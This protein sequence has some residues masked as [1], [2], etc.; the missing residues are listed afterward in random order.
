MTNK[1]PGQLQLF[2]NDEMR[3]NYLAVIVL[4]ALALL[5]H[6]PHIHGQVG[7]FNYD[8]YLHYN[9]S[10][11]FSANLAYGDLY[12]RWIF[13]GRYGMGEPVFFIYSPL[14]Y[15]LVSIFEL[16]GLSTWN[17]IHWVGV[18][19][20]FIFAWFVFLAACNYINY[21]FAL[22]I[23]AT[24]LISPFLV[25]L[26]YKFHGI[27]WAGLGYLSHGMLLWALVRKKADENPYFNFWAALAIALSIGSHIIS[28]LINLICYSFFFLA[29]ILYATKSSQK[30]ANT[31]S[32]VLNWAST[33]IVGLL[34]SAAY[35]FPALYYLNLI[36]AE[37]WEGDYRLAAFAWP[38]LTLINQ[39]TM[40]ISMQWPIAVP[41]ILMFLVSV[42]YV[43]R[44]GK[45]NLGDLKP[46]V[47]GG[48]FVSS[49]AVF[50]AS[51]LSYLVWTFQNPISQINLPYRF[52]FILYTVAG[53]VAGLLLYHSYSSEKRIW[54]LSIMSI[55]GLSFIMSIGLLYKAS[56]IDGS[57]IPLEIIQN[58]YTFQMLESDFKQEGYFEKCADD[59][60]N[61]VSYH[62]SAGGFRGVPE[63]HLKWEGKDYIT[64]AQMDYEKYCARSGFVCNKPERRGSGLFFDFHINSNS[65]V[66]LPAF[67]FPG[68]KVSVDERD[69]PVNI[70][71]NTGLLSINLLSGNHQVMLYREATFVEI[72]GL[73]T[74]IFILSLLLIFYLW[75]HLRAK[76]DTQVLD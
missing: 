25:M 23:A 61:C 29:K 11:E 51:E 34:L 2:G 16:G 14:H 72:V 9:W 5:L 50:F 46:V 69:V 7:D 52:V 68:W 36:S 67:Y 64:F 62:R 47:I 66:I 30:S 70:D 60:K 20:N 24:T 57:K 65:S 59:K 13:H 4:F 8:F 31:K 15:Y 76:E 22:I 48:L 21:K 39:K 35:L 12:P 75:K 32:I 54:S 1:N 3:N 26:H 71:R 43:I 10:K 55:M 6:F 42:A 74:T 49:A 37:A 41:G 56:Y 73:Y 27:S 63:Y 28:A 44:V 19:T 45:D 33:V 38:I 53:F 18:V 58:Q 17:A 40:W